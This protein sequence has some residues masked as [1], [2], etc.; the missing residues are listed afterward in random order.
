VTGEALTRDY[1]A[2]LLRHLA[3]QEEATRTAGYDLG[4]GALEAGVGLLELVTVH[5]EV[6][7]GVLRDSPPQEVPAVAAAAAGLLVEVLASY[8]MVQRGLPR[9]T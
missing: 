4:R 9:A 8:D 1:R 3:Q 6:L 7:A 5:H 2:A